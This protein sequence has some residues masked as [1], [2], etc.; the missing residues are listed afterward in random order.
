MKHER[1][2]V[3]KHNTVHTHQHFDAQNLTEQL[4]ML[5]FFFI[6]KFSYL[7]LK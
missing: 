2:H 1:L 6:L 4:I 3:A 7:N 5:F